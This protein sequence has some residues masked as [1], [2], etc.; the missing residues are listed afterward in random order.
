MLAYS[1]SKTP[2]TLPG[3]LHSFRPVL[4]LTNPTGLSPLVDS[5]YSFGYSF[6]FLSFSMPKYLMSALLHV[7]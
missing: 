3:K 7:L 5:R 4:L 2:P 1:K 6:D